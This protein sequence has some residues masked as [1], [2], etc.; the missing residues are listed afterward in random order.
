MVTLTEK[1]S[2]QNIDKQIE[3]VLEILLDISNNK[4]IEYKSEFQSSM[5]GIARRKIAIYPGNIV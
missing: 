1:L 3:K 5:A 4:L 2:S